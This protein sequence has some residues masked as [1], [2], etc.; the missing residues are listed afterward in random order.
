MPL[1]VKMKN[2]YKNFKE[3]I[4][5]N[6]D[7]NR[8]HSAEYV[9]N[10]HIHS[11]IDRMHKPLYSLEIATNDFYLFNVIKAKMKGLRHSME[12]EQ[13]ITVNSIIY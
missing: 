11:I 5:I 6:F 12:E 9:Q 1:N 4:W 8:V 13:K 10:F 3:T 7:S 2:Q